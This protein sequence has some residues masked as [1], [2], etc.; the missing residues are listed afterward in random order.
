MHLIQTENLRLTIFEDSTVVLPEVPYWIKMPQLDLF[1]QDAFPLGRWP[2]LRETAVVLTEKSLPAANAALNVVA[3][4]A[5]KNRVP[6]LRAHLAHNLRTW[7]NPQGPAYRR[8]HV[9]AAQIR[10]GKGAH[11]RPRSMR[12]S[13]PQ[14]DRPQPRTDE[15]I[16]FWPRSSAAQ[17]QTT[18]QNLSDVRAA[19]PWWAIFPA[20]WGPAGRP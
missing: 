5:Q 10:H 17:P 11:R 16:H 13:F 19:S 8:P 6:A 1:F 15:P 7:K 9:Y 18:P 12:L 20:L 2:D 3:L 14:L 4:C